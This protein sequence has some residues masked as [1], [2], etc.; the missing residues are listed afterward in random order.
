MTLREREFI[1]AHRNTDRHIHT[2][3]LVPMCSP[4]FTSC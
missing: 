4:L 2:V 1:L 3:A